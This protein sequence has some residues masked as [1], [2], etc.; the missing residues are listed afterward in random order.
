MAIAFRNTEYDPWTPKAFVSHLKGMNRFHMTWFLS[1]VQIFNY[2]SSL[3][4]NGKYW[5]GEQ[6]TKMMRSEWHYTAPFWGSQTQDLSQI[7][8]YTEYSQLISIVVYTKNCMI[9]F[10][11]EISLKKNLSYLQGCWY[12]SFYHC[13]QEALYFKVQPLGFCNES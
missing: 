4:R 5:K 11:K 2:I 9:L 12:S 1:T 6:R 13:Q 8:K 7:P 10:I 3:W